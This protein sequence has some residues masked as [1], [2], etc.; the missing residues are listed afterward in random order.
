MVIENTAFAS[1]LALHFPDRFHQLYD[2]NHEWQTILE[3]SIGFTLK[4][5][6]TD[7]ETVKAIDLVHT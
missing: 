3:S 5:G 1:D 6:L 4:T 2:K 7:T